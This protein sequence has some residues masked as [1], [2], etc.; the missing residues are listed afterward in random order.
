MLKKVYN[1]EYVITRD[2]LPDLHTYPIRDD[3]Q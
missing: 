1:S 2:E 3:A